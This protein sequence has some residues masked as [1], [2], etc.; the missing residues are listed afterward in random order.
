M[1]DEKSGEK[2]L[3]TVKGMLQRLYGFLNHPSVSKRLGAYSAILHVSQ[4]LRRFRRFVDRFLLEIFYHLI[5]SL[6]IKGHEDRVLGT[7]RAAVDALC[8]F[9]KIM[10]RTEYGRRQPWPSCWRRRR[11]RE[12][13]WARP[14]AAAV[15]WRRGAA[16]GRA[17]PAR[18]EGWCSVHQH[19]GSG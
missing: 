1:T 11:N 13:R 19:D 15:E 14:V 3:E 10:F 17:G 2:D 7:E 6:R 18:S 12:R 9:E 8:C 5:L 16:R 4:Y